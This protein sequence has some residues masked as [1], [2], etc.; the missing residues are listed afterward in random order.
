MAPITDNPDSRQIRRM[1]L[2]IQRGWSDLERRR[3]QMYDV[4]PVRVTQTRL[5]LDASVNDEESG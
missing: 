5:S 3:R 4:D 1:C 2:Q